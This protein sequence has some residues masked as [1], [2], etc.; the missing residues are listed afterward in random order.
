MAC[1]LSTATRLCHTTHV[2]VHIIIVHASRRVT[3]TGPL[4]MRTTPNR[5]ISRRRRG[6]RRYACA[7]R[8]HWES[9]VKH[10]HVALLIGRPHDLLKQSLRYRKYLI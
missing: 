7:V 1:S 3:D 9:T 8:A 10:Q 5:V 6:R 4:P 2:T